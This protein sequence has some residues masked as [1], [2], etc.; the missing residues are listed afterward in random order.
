MFLIKVMMEKVFC[1]ERPQVVSAIMNRHGLHTTYNVG[2]E[3]VADPKGYGCYA[4]AFPDEHSFGDV[5][6]AVHDC[7]AEPSTEEWHEIAVYHGLM[8]EGADGYGVI[9]AGLIN[10]RYSENE[11]QAIVNNRLL[12]LDEVEGTRCF[13]EEELGRKTDIGSEYFEMQEF[14]MECKRLARE[15]LE[16]Q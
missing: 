10:A 7:G 9:V 11:M 13:A 5:A 4:I 14:R 1:E 15:I 6:K 8:D 3:E 16:L 2:C 12:L